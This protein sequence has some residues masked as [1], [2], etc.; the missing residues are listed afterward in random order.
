MVRHRHRRS[1]VYGAAAVAA[2]CAAAPAAVMTMH[3]LVNQGAP[4]LAALTLGLLLYAFSRE[5]S[6][7]PI[8][9]VF[10]GAQTGM[11]LYV[12]TVLSQLVLDEDRGLR[13]V[14]IGFL[15]TAIQQLVAFLA[16]CCFLALGRLV[17]SPYEVK[18][19]TSSRERVAVLCFSAAFALNIGLNNFSQTMLSLSVNLII[20]SCLPLST[21]VSELALGSLVQ[22]PG[23]TGLQWALMLAGVLGTVCVSYVKSAAQDVDSAEFSPLGLF[24]AVLSICAG[25]L[26]MVLAG[27]LGTGIKLNPLDSTFYMAVPAGLIMILFSFVEH[28]VHSWRDFPAVTDWAIVQEVVSRYP[29][30]MLPVV[31]SGVFAFVY[32]CLQYTLVQQL[33]ATHAAFAGSFNMAATIAFSLCLGYEQIPDGWHGHLF[34]LAIAGNIGA[35]TAFNVLRNSGK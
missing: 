18:K 8:L 9:L 6:S 4:S 15:M 22:R 3:S 28:P 19:L 11:N 20:R 33:S 30:A 14:P 29:W 1:L 7:L 12:K 34:L 5:G 26:N 25:A 32:N 27:V 2:T 23:L 24:C 13:G 31:I 10:F 17:G 21:A 16:F 35:F